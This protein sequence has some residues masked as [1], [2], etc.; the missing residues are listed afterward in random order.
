MGSS[1]ISLGLGL[2]GGKSG[3]SS[4]RLPGGG[5]LNNLYSVDF[6]GSDEYVEIDSSGT[7]GTIAFWFKPDN[8]I[9]ASSAHQI[10]IG[11]NGNVGLGQ[12]GGVQ[13]GSHSGSVTNEIIALVT[14]DWIYAYADASATISTD[15]HHVAVTWTGS[16]YHIYL[17]GNQVKNHD[18]QWYSGSKTEINF[19]ALEF[20]R[21]NQS[22]PHYNGQ[23]DEVAIWHTALSASDTAALYNSGLPGD[24]TSLNPNGWWRNGDNNGGTGSTITDQGSGGNDGTLENGASFSTDVPT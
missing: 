10:P 19:S 12:Y 16:D 14:G 3:T 4:G 17:D 11:F 1:T 22:S 2:G 8:V 18:G 9:S 23:L 6:D 15:W 7:L 20:G 13:F 5:G 21:R 24:L